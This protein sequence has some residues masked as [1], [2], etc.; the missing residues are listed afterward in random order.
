MYKWLSW[1]ASPDVQEG[2]SAFTSDA[3]ANPAACRGAA[4]ANCSQYH[5]SSLPVAR[6]IVFE[7]LPVGDC[8]NGQAGCTTYE[9]W[10]TAWQRVSPLP[11]ATATATASTGS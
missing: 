6:N 5:E 4:A 7:H 2:V 11:G 8:G 10:Q 1:S 3:P 9:Q